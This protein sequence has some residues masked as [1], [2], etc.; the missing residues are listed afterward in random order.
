[1]ACGHDPTS[2]DGSRP[3]LAEHVKELES[4]RFPVMIQLTRDEVCRTAVSRPG[5]ANVKADQPVGH[6]VAANDFDVSMAAVP[7]LFGA[8][9][10]VELCA[11][12]MR[13][14]RCRSC[15]A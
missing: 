14:G 7:D 3:L 15:S 1:V 2:G 5:P 11:Y 12:D 8:G 10:E 6:S 4:C 13:Y 9:A